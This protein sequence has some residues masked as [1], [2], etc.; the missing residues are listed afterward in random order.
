M[1]VFQSDGSGEFCNNSLES[2]FESKGISQQKS[3][4]YTLEQNGIVER[5]HRHIVETAVS[6]IFHSSVPLEFSPYAFSTAVFLINRMP[7]PSL[8]ML[9]PFEK[10]FGNTPDLRYLKV[11]GCACYSLLKPNTKH[12]LEPKTTQHIFL[13]YPHNFKGYLCYNP[14]T[15]QTIVSRLVTFHEIIFPFAQSSPSSPSHTKSISDPNLLLTLLNLPQFSNSTSPQSPTSNSSTVD[16]TCSPSMDTNPTRQSLHVSS[17]V[18]IG[19][20]IDVFTTNAPTPH[21]THAMQTRA[22]S[23]IFKPKA[24]HITTT[25]PTPTSYTEASKYP[26]WRNAM[27]EEFNA[28]QAQ[29]TWSLVP[30]HPSMNIVGYKWVFR[31]KYNLDGSVARHK[32]RLVSKGYHQVHGFDF[33][34]TFSPV[35]KKPTIR[36]ILALVA[37][38]SWSLT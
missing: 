20:A 17:I 34:E 37:Q 12:K 6:L 19:N 9:S 3:C 38:Y 15:K 2:F 27:C 4:P 13:G 35:V 28:L 11:F 29:G 36:I 31:I 7:S 23:G 25:I 22:K 14:S 30:Q 16:N 10:L 33:D 18:D 26:E 5:K 24:F 21:N 1:K 8:H 32:A